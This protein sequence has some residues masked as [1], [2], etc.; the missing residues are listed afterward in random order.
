MF[1]FY[2]HFNVLYDF[3]NALLARLAFESWWFAQRQNKAHRLATH[4]THKKLKDRQHIRQLSDRFV[5]VHIAGITEI[6]QVLRSKNGCR[7]VHSIWQSRRNIADAIQ[8][9]TV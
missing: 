3:V 8:L 7:K 6:A 5:D 2:Y 9:R 1:F 4:K